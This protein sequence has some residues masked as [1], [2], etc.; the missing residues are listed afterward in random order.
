MDTLAALHVDPIRTDP[1]CVFGV[2][3]VVRI[4]AQRHRLPHDQA[5]RVAVAALKATGDRTAAILAGI[6]SLHD[7]G[8][9]LSAP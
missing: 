5:E 8:S 6:R 3:R 9:E 1:G 2:R 7:E 4:A